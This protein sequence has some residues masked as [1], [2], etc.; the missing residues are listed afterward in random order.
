MLLCVCKAPIL[1]PGDVVTLWNS[2]AS[3]RN[4]SIVVLAPRDDAFCAFL[5]A[6]AVGYIMSGAR[7]NV[8]GKMVLVTRHVSPDANVRRDYLSLDAQLVIL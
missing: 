8:P 3:A 2:L 1:T 7:V 4:D 6:A 5:D